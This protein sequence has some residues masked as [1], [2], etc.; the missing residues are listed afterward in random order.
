[1]KT[2]I[3]ITLICLVIAGLSIT[4]CKKVIDGC[5]D[6][7]ATN[8]NAKATEDDGSCTYPPLCEVNKTG[9]V[10]FKN[11]SN[12][13][14]TYDIIWDG[15]KIATI[16]PNQS[17]QVFTYSANV[18]HTLVFRYT[19]TSNNACTPSTPYLTQCQQLGFNCSY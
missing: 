8:Y 5:T 2:L 7:K 17:S 10:Y 19:N 13:N 4:S 9:E 11:I 18:Q 14:S 1:M 12:S 16:T 6:P 15:V 3:S